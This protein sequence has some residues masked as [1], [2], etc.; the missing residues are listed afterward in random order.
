[1]GLLIFA[2][3]E[4]LRHFHNFCRPARPRK[5]EVFAVLPPN[6]PHSA[7]TAVSVAVENDFLVPFHLVCKKIE[8]FINIQLTLQLYFYFLMIRKGIMPWKI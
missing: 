2:A 3:P 8:P 6:A 5:A 7:G 4:A 1:V